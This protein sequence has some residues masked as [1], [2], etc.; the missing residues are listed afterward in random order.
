MSDEAR[1]QLRLSL[2]R[3]LTANGDRFGLTARYLRTLALSEERRELSAA[4]V[5]RELEYLA[6]AEK[7][8]VAEVSKAVSPECRT[9]KITAKGRDFCAERGI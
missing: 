8:L 6:D 2:L 4:D 7:G 3:F 5:E 9:W 1:E